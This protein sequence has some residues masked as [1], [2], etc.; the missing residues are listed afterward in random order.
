[1]VTGCDWSMAAFACGHSPMHKIIFYKGCVYMYDTSTVQMAILAQVYI[2]SFHIFIVVACP[3]IIIRDNALTIAYVD[4]GVAGK[5]GDIHV[6]GDMTRD[7]I[8]TTTSCNS[9]IKS[10]CAAMAFQAE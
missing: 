8:R 1:M 10:I 4:I 3:A 5:F 2:A 9:M 7:A 6:I